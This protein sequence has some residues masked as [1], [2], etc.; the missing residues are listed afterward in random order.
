MTFRKAGTFRTAVLCL[1][2]FAMQASALDFYKSDGRFYSG[3]PRPDKEVALIVGDVD[4]MG[5]CPAFTRLMEEGKPGKQLFM[6]KTLVEVLPSRYTISVACGH[7]G[8]TYI[9]R[10]T[11][12]DLVIDA[13]PGHVYCVRAENG[14]AHEKHLVVADISRDEDYG[15]FKSGKDVKKHVDRYFRGKRHEV[16]EM[17][18]GKGNMAW[19]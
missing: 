2:L 7:I 12:S 16:K 10:Y 11:F 14:P 6:G 17:D 8:Y 18:I 9:T 13:Q 4:L 1:G 3:E 19:N 5:E 15:T